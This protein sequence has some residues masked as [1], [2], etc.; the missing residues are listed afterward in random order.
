MTMNMATSNYPQNTN[1]IYNTFN[2]DNF[3]GIPNNVNN[4]MGNINGNVP[5]WNQGT[6]MNPNTIYPVMDQSYYNRSINPTYYNNIYPNKMVINNQIP[7][8]AVNQYVN[9][10]FYNMGSN[11]FNSNQMMP[12]SQQQMPGNFRN[13]GM[14]NK[15]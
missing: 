2:S 3:T 12:I 4:F 8:L 15:K 6:T 11:N 7:P 14:R 13:F 1:K 10:I 5:Y 9:Q